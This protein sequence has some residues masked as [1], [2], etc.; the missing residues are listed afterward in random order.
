MH[1]TNQTSPIIRLGLA[2]LTATVTCC[3]PAA[4]ISFNRDIRPI[5][6]D[7]CFACH[8]PDERTRE[9]GLRLDLREAATREHKGSRGIHPGAPESS[10]IMARI[11]TEDP[12]DRMPPS[13][14][15]KTLSSHEVELLREWIK[16]GAE[17]QDHWAFVPPTRP[18][19]PPVASHA[20]A[21][22]IN[23]IDNFVRHRLK[24]EG[25]TPSEEAQ[26][27][28]LI[29]R[30]T[31]DLTGLPPTLE[32]VD[33]F[34]N[35]DDANA[36]EK[37]V[38][39]LLASER[40]GERM[41]LQWMDAARY[42]DTSVFHADGPRDMWPWRDWVI[43]A[44]N[45]NKPF[46][47]FTLEQI[48]GDLI[49]NATLE[50]KIA[51][52]FNRNNGTTD[53]GGVI[54]EEYRIEYA[55]DR[56]KTTATVWLALSME[57]GQCHDHKYDPISQKDYY[58]F[59]AFFNQS[60]DKGMQTRKGNAEPLVRFFTEDQEIRHADLTRQLASVDQE[61]AV[62]RPLALQGFAD[63]NE[64]MTKA[65]ANPLP[66]PANL[67][68]HF[69]LDHVAD[70]EIT[71]TVSG[72]TGK[73]SKG[74][75]VAVERQKEGPALKLDGKTIAPI[76]GVK[77]IDKD[78]PFT[79][80]AWVRL[81][82]GKTGGPIFARM[83]VA[84]GY[85]GYDFWL[86]GNSVGTHFISKWSSDAIKVVS[87][88]KVPEGKWTH[89]AVTY[90][91]GLKAA[92]VKIYINGKLAQNKVEADTL[93][94]ST[95]TKSPF[96]IAARSTG[97]GTKLDVDDI[98]IF[99]RALEAEEIRTLDVDPIQQIL[100]LA[101]DKRTDNQVDLLKNHYLLTQ[102]KPYAGLAKRRKTLVG[103]RQK[104]EASK[105]TT[106]IM[107]EASPMRPT[108]VLNRGMY[109]APKKE[110]VIPADVPRALGSL[111]Q[112][113]PANRLGLA[114]WLTAG[115]NPLT[116]R[117]AVNRYW[118]M[119]FG[120]G[121]VNTMDDFGSQGEWPSHPNLLDW[122]AVDFVESGWNVK[123]MLKQIVMSATYRQ[124]S[125]VTPELKDRDPGNRL[126]ARGPRFRL[127]GEFIRDNAL[128]LSGLLVDTV[129][130]P[131]V[132][133]YQPPGLWNEVSLSGNVRFVADK[134]RKLFRRSMYTYWKRSAP[135]P[136]MIIF[137][138]PSREKCVVQ[139]QRTNTPL[140]ALVTLND[141]QFVEASRHLAARILR[142]GGKSDAAKLEF[143]WR[144]ATSR[145][146]SMSKLQ[147]LQD[148]LDDQRKLFQASP[149]KA[150]QYLGVG[151]TKRHPAIAPAQHAA[152][153]VIANLLL[154]LDEALTRG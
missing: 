63:W 104:L 150:E 39:R 97:S 13:D 46:N 85:R 107:G 24:Q 72:A 117:V 79:F 106:M 15:N 8:G 143:A 10:S 129:G 26:R 74:K 65:D 56:V 149:E 69:S 148:L 84:N 78:T 131:G 71:D 144:L 29:R 4:E 34:V 31:F 41:A 100:A 32:Q 14:S 118:S 67:V 98:K 102:D 130:G 40:Y 53:E 116:A 55:V 22:A 19:V 43:Q 113:A 57:C 81:P 66:P 89:V 121:L 38:D 21:P 141:P 111:P 120:N 25:L 153:T 110:E 45:A 48:A 20:G 35:D 82:K 108:Y 75:L 36:Y 88:E 64:R 90:D 9:G 77:D 27:E 44:Y 47:E 5:L 105:M 95:L 7:N 23:P 54:P 146:P 140:Q 152:W 33:A 80:A 136:S 30:A 76:E 151:D 115:D 18:E 101:P 86:Q 142:G 28:I 126:L 96:Q 16:Q 51:S 99:H 154:N 134:G 42:G 17:W 91:G 92:G 137:D 124:S 125:R 103:Q 123:R 37:V 112:G 147:M 61:L 122:L 132:K 109:D 52:A 93:K 49:P 62:R 133:P 60:S 114:Q 139:R 70:G 3:V 94:N 59:F 12:E 128:A 127:P 138:A 135:A 119:L 87:Q 73:A 145:P 50:Q 2:L 83:D 6:S 1:S 11:T 58:G 68:H